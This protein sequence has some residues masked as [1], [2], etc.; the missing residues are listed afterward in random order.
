MDQT[1]EVYCGAEKPFSQIAE[2]LGYGTFTLDLNPEYQPNL[3]GDVSEVLAKNIPPSPLIIWAAPPYSDAFQEIDYW[4]SDGSFYPRNSEAQDAID[5]I[6]NTISLITALK[7]T[8][9]FIENP[10]SLLRTMP[11]FSGFN[12]GYVPNA[13]W[14]VFSVLSHAASRQRQFRLIF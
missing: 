6:R 12:R 7:P 11:L 1:I 8:W 13:L 2:A 3:V 4:E 14:T 5:K 9:W 10:K